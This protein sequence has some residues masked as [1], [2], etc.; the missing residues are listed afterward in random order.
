MTHQFERGRLREDGSTFGPVGENS[1][2]DGNVTL[3]HVGE[4]FLGERGRGRGTSEVMG[5]ETTAFRR[6]D[7]KPSRNLTAP[8]SGRCES[9]LLSRRWGG[10]RQ[11]SSQC[12]DKQ[13]HECVSDPAGDLQVLRSRVDEVKLSE[14]Q[15][16]V[17]LRQGPAGNTTE[18]EKVK[19]DGE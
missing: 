13:R 18:E 15:G 10:E 9:R 1:S 6:L 14:A 11:Q 12:S 17:G 3:Q 19:A 8:P 2:T 7:H 5:V 4:A 16:S